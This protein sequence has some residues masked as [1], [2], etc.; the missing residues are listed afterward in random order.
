MRFRNLFLSATWSRHTAESAVVRAAHPS[1][2]PAPSSTLYHLS[3]PSTRA[4]SLHRPASRPTASLRR[5]HYRCHSWAAQFS[6][7][8][9]AEEGQLQTTRCAKYTRP[10]ACAECALVTAHRAHANTGVFF[11]PGR[12]R[13]RPA[14]KHLRSPRR[15]AAH[16]TRR[17]RG[18]ALTVNQHWADAQARDP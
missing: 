5:V 4:Q 1:P 17:R 10:P 18:C 6:R 12:A 16:S 8:Q 2:S 13:M 7:A 15:V 3:P 9:S 14:R 11:R